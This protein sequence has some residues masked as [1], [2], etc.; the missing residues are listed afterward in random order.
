MNEI[1]A[2]RLAWDLLKARL[3]VKPSWG[4]KEVLDLMK[5]CLIEAYE[6]VE[7]VKEGEV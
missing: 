6:G 2:Y 4:C 1:T 5:D 3:R 7:N